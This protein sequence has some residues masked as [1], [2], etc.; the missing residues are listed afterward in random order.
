LSPRLSDGCPAIRQP[1]DR[2]GGG[3]S[4]ENSVLSLTNCTVSTNQANGAT[5]QGGGIY[6]LNSTV[7]VQNSTVNGNQANGTVL[8]QGGGIYRSGGVLTL[9]ASI[10]NGN[11]ATTAFDDIF[12]PLE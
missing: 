3:T 10:V 9:L 2:P 1:E 6:A 5:A 11:Q 7:T 12:P 8:G 4:S